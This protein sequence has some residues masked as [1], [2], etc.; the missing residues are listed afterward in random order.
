MILSERDIDALRL[1]CW[2][3]YVL[4]VDLGYVVTDTELI[5]LVSCGLLKYH[6]R[7]Q[8]V[9][10]TSKGRNLLQST[11]IAALPSL[12]K[13]YHDT[14]IQRRLRQSILALT[15][16]HSGIN[17]FTTQPEQLCAS[18]SLFLSALTRDRGT[19]PWGN[20]RI[21]ALA[22]IGDMAYAIYCIYPDV[23]KLV[24]IDE[25]TAF[26]NQTAQ[27]SNISRAV[28]FAGESYT[29]I[30]TELEV[31]GDADTK[32]I[33]YG[34]AYR[35]LQ[36]PVHLLSCDDTGAVQLQIMSAPDYRR[37]LTQAALKGQYQ[38]PPEDAPPWDAIFQGLPFV[39][40]ADMDLRRV[41]AAVRLARGRGIRQ[42]A[43]AALRGQA[44]TVLFPRYRDTGLAR[45]FI[46]TDEAVSEVTGRP[47]VPYVPPRTQF[48]TP[49]GDVVDAPPIQA[50][51]KA[52]GRR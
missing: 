48:V 1:I 32:L 43:I 28:I 21:A 14:A 29:D 7:S 27:I 17:I 3:Q 19:N 11:V 37:K 6:T 8:A 52:G 24:L 5:N 16:Y 2:C 42:T 38:P 25:L 40:A 39:M 47:P 51:G 44:E 12:T 49:K 34:D 4:P 33:R 31:S 35:S 26:A 13:S 18:Q 15:A 20:S 45:V 30:L 36:L 9:T 23:G 46:L 50:A 22:H 10:L 41:D